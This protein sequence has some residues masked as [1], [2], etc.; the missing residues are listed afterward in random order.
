MPYVA[1]F[2]GTLLL[3]LLGNG[4]V[5]NVALNG[6][7]GSNGGFLMVTAGWGV[8][9]AIGVYASGHVSG[10]HINPA[11]TLAY[12]IGG[13][14][15]WALV[16]GYIAAQLLGAMT[17]CLLV[18]ITYGSQYQLTDDSSAI[19]ATF[20]TT[21][22]IRHTR[23]NCLTEMIGTAILV[24]GVLSIFAAGNQISPALGPALV[25]LLVF[26]IGMS[27]GGPTGYAINPA[28]DLGPRIMHAILPIR[29]KGKTDWAYAWIPVVAPFAG[30]IIGGVL[31]H[32]T[33]LGSVP[34]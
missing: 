16:P 25:G 5:A 3:I 34:I 18:Y 1:E 31:F 26:G 24:F 20:H 29:A 4:V 9:V 27:L 13:T 12:A 19:A 15:S 23:N 11:V 14:F 33:K 8:A 6:S 30:G 17:G 22:E 2:V 7:K 28:R 21:P 10:G 32:F